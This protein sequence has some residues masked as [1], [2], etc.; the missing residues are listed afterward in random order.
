MYLYAERYGA[1][2]ID[3]PCMMCNYPLKKTLLMRKT[4]C[5]E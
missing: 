3:K 2:S 5:T 1:I 4:Q